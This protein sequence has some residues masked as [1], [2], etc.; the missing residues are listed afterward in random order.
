MFQMKQTHIHMYVC[1]FV[2]FILTD[3]A[4]LVCK[5]EVIGMEITLVFIQL[6]QYMRKSLNAQLT[7]WN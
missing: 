7:P 3:V 5:V 1:T 6:Q 2:G 4:L